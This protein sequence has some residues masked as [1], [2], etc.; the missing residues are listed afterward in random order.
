MGVQQYLLYQM[1]E[2]LCRPFQRLPHHRVLSYHLII[3]VDEMFVL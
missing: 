3:L 1:Q 2:N